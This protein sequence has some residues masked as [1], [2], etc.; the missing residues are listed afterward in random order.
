MLDEIKASQPVVRFSADPGVKM[1]TLA[2]VQEILR[3]MEMRWVVFDKQGHEWETSSKEKDS[4]EYYRH[5]YILVED[6]NM[7]YTRKSYGQLIE[8]EKKRLL[9]PFIMKPTGSP[10]PALYEKWKDKETYAI[11]IDGIDIENDR[12]NDYLAVDFK[13]YFQSGVMKNARSKRFPQPY[14]VHL[15]TK[16]YGLP[17]PLTNQD[18]IT[19]TSRFVTWGRDIS[20]YPDPNTAYLQK[21]ARYEKLRTS[22]TIYSQ[23]SAQEKALLDSLYIELNNEYFQSSD[24][25]KKSLKQPISPDSDSPRN[26]NATQ[27]NG[28]K[29]AVQNK[30]SLGGKEL[31]YAFASSN[32]SRS[33]GLQEYLALY[34]KYQTVTYENRLFEQPVVWGVL[35]QQKMF[36]QLE[37]KYNGLSFEE[38]RQ[39]KRATFPYVKMESGGKEV[40]VKIED[41]T[42]QQRKELGC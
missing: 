26:G 29:I 41:L 33:A 12:L 32:G 37:A 5:A 10:D 30:G 36:K 4:E 16:D 38:R 6:E 3:G 9:G 25:R 21:N 7:N 1:G 35:H 23:K 22:G 15:Y 8:E 17:N 11:W 42:P 19:L 14:Q 34:G 13:Y 28:E 40:F 24:K 27:N 18:T 2:D 39:V 20:K 31:V